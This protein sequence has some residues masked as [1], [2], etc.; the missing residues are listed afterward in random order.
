MSDLYCKNC[1]STDVKFSE[2]DYLSAIGVLECGF[3]GAN[4]LEEDF[5]VP[6][7]EA[8]LV[9]NWDADHGVG[10]CAFCGCQC[11]EE[12]STRDDKTGQYTCTDCHVSH[13]GAQSEIASEEWRADNGYGTCAMCAC[14]TNPENSSQD[15]KTGQY[16]C[17]QCLDEI[18]AVYGYCAYCNTEVHEYD[19]R[20]IEETGQFSCELCDQEHAEG[21]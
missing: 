13:D 8:T 21:Y 10:E 19:C 9:E 20:R 1:G 15:P 4:G 16:C 11:T 18:N 7:F 3:C 2:D 12:S 5:G 6:E 17:E 14:E